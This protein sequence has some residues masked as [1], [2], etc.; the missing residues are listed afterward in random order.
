MPAKSNL[1]GAMW[2]RQHNARFPNSRDLA[3]LAPDFRYRVGRFVDAL[4]WGEAS[5]VVSST[6]RHPSR[7]YLMHYA[8]R[9]AHGQVAA[10]DVPPRSGVDID[11]VHESEKASRDAAMEMVQ[12][13]RMAHVASLTSNHTRG[14]AIDMTITWTGTLLLKLPG[15]GNLWEIPDRPRTGAGNTELHRLGADLFR[16]HKLASDPPHWSHDGH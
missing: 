3:D 7:A 2:W 14:T 9:V 15:S 5:V 13:A 11:W 1:S 6:L 10:E 12:L 16:V 4:R 8:W